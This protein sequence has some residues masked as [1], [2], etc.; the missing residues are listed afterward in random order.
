MDRVFIEGLRVDALIGVYGWER[1]VRQ[2]LMLDLV[3]AWDNRVPGMSDDVTQALDYGRVAEAVA[4]WVGESRFQL[5]EALAES[6][7]QKL[8]DEFEVPGLQLTIRKPGAVAS[9]V[10]VGVS[11][12]RGLRLGAENSA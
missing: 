8:M 1:E 4:G 3:M 12:N 11:I 6:L 9:A 2:T 5:L 10:S 7:A